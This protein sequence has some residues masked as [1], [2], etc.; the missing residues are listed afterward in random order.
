[1]DVGRIWK[2]KE[3]Q[4]NYVKKNEIEIYVF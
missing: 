4:E 3:N 2:K 1:M